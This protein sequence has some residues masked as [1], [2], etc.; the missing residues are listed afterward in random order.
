MI[1]ELSR[2]QKILLGIATAWPV[3]YIFGFI[4]FIFG[5]IAFAGGRDGGGEMNPL[6]AGGFVVLFLVHLV[7]IFLIMALTVFYIIHAVKNTK[8]DTNMRVIWIV[9]FFFGGLVA[10]PIYWY[11]QIWREPKPEFGE[12]MPPPASSWM[13]E[14]PRQGSYVPPAEPPDWR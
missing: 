10:N 6:F 14:T 3:V 12:L 5:F 7:T 1:M 2:M 4:A 11:L 8:L 13:S 9:L